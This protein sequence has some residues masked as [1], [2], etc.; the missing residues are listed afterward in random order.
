MGT[1]VEAWERSVGIT[2]DPAGREV[3]EL[4]LRTA[5]MSVAVWTYGATLVEVVVDRAGA[6]PNVVTRLPDLAAYEQRSGRRYIGATMGRFAR[7]VGGGRLHI[8]PR[9]HQLALNAG[10]HH[11]HGGPDGFDA[12]VWDGAA[13]A[14]S[15]RGHIGL[16]LVSRAGDQ[17]YPGELRA[18]ATFTLD[19][20]DRLTISYEAEADQPTLVGMTNHAFWNLAGGGTIDDHTLQVPVLAQLEADLEFIPTGRRLPVDGTDLDVRQG[21]SLRGLALD[22]CV[23]VARGVAATVLTHPGSGRRMELASN[24]GCMALYTGDALDPPRGG[25]CLQPGAY[26]DAPNR[27][28]FPSALLAPGAR[29]RN[30]TTF[31]FTWEDPDRG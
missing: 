16:D 26:P 4:G 25:L 22:H 24:Q 5:H 30:R 13:T 7:V 20:E 12:R 14:G 10:A 9:L 8:G 18:R 31:R 2:S 11:L 6:A 27:P 29:Y 21:R 1:G 15:D 19:E 28:E 23:E 17:G 3:H